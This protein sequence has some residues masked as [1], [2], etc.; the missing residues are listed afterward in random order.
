M[1]RKIAFVSTEPDNQEPMRFRGKRYTIRR[2][3]AIQLKEL[4]VEPIVHRP[5]ADL[6]D[7]PDVRGYHGVIVGGSKLNIFDDDVAANPW[8]DKLLDFIRDT[9]EKVPMLGL[10]F[11]HQAIGKAFGG[12]LLK[13]R[14]WYEVGFTPVTLTH[15]GKGD[16]LFKESPETF[17]ALFS[18]FSYISA[19]GTKDLPLIPL[20]TSSDPQNKSVQAFKVGYMT[21]GIQFH[22]EYDQHAIEDLVKARIRMIKHMVDVGQ[23]LQGLQRTERKD[24]Q[25]FVNFVDF[26]RKY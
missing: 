10:C 3:V 13:Y 14:D 2:S 9:N 6:S 7:F 23:V 1:R 24:I 4:G 25:P 19:N 18:H 22:P 8:M 11:G 26:V 20:L 17:D 21:W 15:A 5:I 12:T 16:P